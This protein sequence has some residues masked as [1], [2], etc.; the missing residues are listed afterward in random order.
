MNGDD[1]CRSFARARRAIRTRAISCEELVLR[2]L[3]RIGK[4]NEHLN[5]FT[6]VTA[7]QALE[8]ARAVDRDIRRGRDLPLAGLVLAVKD[9][10]CVKDLEVTCASN[11]LRG[12]RSV[13]DATCVARLR[14]AGA[15]IIGKTNCDEF[16]MGSTNEN[17]CF[18]PVT[19]P[20]H[21]AYVPGGS[22]GGSAAAVAAGLC[23]AALGTD[24]GG[25]IRQP[26][27][28]CGVV[29]LKPTYGRVSRSGLVAFA[30]SLDC[31]GTLA[32]TID[33]T[34]AVLESM[35]GLD[36]L[37]A[38]SAPVGVPRY[39]QGLARPAPGLKIG[40]PTE[41]FADGLDDDIRRMLESLVEELR[42]AGA[43]IRPISLPHMKYGIATYYILATA[44][45]SS[46][47]ARFDG[48]RYGKRAGGKGRDVKRIYARSRTEG[49][50]MEVKRR[51]MLG[52]YV[53]SSGYYDAY[54][55]KAQRVRSLVRQDLDAAFNDVD[56]LLTPVTPSP[57]IRVGNLIDD[58]L[59][60][61]LS[62]LYT[63]PANL[64]GVPG[65]VVPIGT[66]PDGLPVGAQFLGRPFDESRL[67]RVGQLAIEL[68]Q[69]SGGFP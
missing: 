51:I 3:E 28:F 19:N 16:A 62:D 5:A 13:Y 9:V 24:T 17:S 1:P 38:T 18:G 52:T 7:C 53:L 31:V 29:G 26:A 69:W 61:Y 14:G 41:C 21:K 11:V 64:A 68:A 46:N 47:L 45:A 27:A 12:F 35:A 42:F 58:P 33:G 65:L 43:E 8:E 37:D 22:S 60:M 50:G 63:V 39:A 55:A 6:V 44:E 54:Y 10:L 34:A 36:P 40:L 48:M 32:H 20:Y 49:F 25:S 4:E 57:G 2:F 15:V 59:K 30:S 66:H 67:L 56:V 23:H